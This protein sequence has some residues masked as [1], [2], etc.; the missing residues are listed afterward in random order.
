ML[1]QTLLVA[2]A[3]VASANMVVPSPHVVKR[4]I[5]ARQTDEAGM[6]ACLSAM[7]ALITDMPTAAPAVT[8]FFVTATGDPCSLSVPP[9]LKS[10]YSS[11]ESAVHSWYTAHSVQWS[12]A[13][14]QCPDSDAFTSDLSGSSCTAADSGNSGSNGGGSGSKTTDSSD[15]QETGSGSGSGSKTSS[16]AGSAAATGGSGNGNGSG[17]NNNNNGNGNGN[18]GKNAGHRDTGL[19]GAAVAIA[20]VLGAVALL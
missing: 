16:G 7:A 10:A 20:G 2:L 4:A 11:Y 9:S 19:A 3:G 14:A 5:E 13:L 6:S 1:S 18:A 15:S 12:S 17:N 8:D